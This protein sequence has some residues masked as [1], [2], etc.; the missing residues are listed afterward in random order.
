ML[1]REYKD[2]LL[3]DRNGLNLAVYL[4]I[5]RGPLAMGSKVHLGE[6]PEWPIGL[7]SKSSVPFSGDRGFD[8]HPLRH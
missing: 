8:S 4:R 6:V 7:D 5:I 1:G 2:Y 3:N